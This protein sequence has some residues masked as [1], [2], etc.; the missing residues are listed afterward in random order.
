MRIF[1]TDNSVNPPI[2]AVYLYSGVECVTYDESR[3]DLIIRLKSGKE[4]T[5]TH[6]TPEQVQ[7]LNSAW[8]ENREF[9]IEG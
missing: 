9:L 5:I 8:L 2:Q 1:R 3:T 7:E 4:V 6:V